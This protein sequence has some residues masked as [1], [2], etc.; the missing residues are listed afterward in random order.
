M[1]IGGLLALLAIMLAVFIFIKRKQVEEPNKEKKDGVSVK[2]PVHIYSTLEPAAP[3]S[4]QE[5]SRPGEED[6]YVAVFFK[7]NTSSSSRSTDKQQPEESVI[8]SSVSR[9]Q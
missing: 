9:C 6:S 5:V 1:A 4:R 7:Q 8:Y 2:Q 3:K